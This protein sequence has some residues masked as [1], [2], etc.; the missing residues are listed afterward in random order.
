MSE[1][2][3]QP[4]SLLMFSLLALVLTGAFFVVPKN[5]AAAQQPAEIDAVTA[6]TY[7]RQIGL[8]PANLATAGI[9]AAGATN[10]VIGLLAHL[11]SNLPLIRSAEASYQSVRAQHDALLRTVRQGD[12]TG[13]AL[14]AL[15]DARVALAAAEV[16]LEALREELFADATAEFPLLQ[17]NELQTIHSNRAHR[18]PAA[19]KI[20]DRTETAWLDIR[21]ALAAERIALE[22][23]DA[24]PD[25]SASLLASVRGEPAVAAAQAAFDVRYD[26]VATAIRTVLATL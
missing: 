18:G 14:P 7:L 3:K 16:A 20:A 23:G 10:A 9:D 5:F 13:E 24:V 4:K 1:Y 8:S 15:Q 19:F 21:S 6:E 17:R 2:L 11:Q 22:E 12:S 26:S 25:Q